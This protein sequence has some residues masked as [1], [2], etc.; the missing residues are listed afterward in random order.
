MMIQYFVIN[1]HTFVQSGSCCTIGCGRLDT[2]Q[3]ENFEFSLG[4]SQTS[5][6]AEVAMKRGIPPYWHKD[7]KELLSGWELNPGLR[8]AEAV[9]LLT[10]R[11]TNHYTTRDG[12]DFQWTVCPG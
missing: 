1:A 2:G 3:Q 9:M 4:R 8:R 5:L 6:R 11:N 10:S 12:L 7:K